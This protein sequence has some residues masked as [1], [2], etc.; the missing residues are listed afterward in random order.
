MSD[1]HFFVPAYFTAEA[2]ASFRTR[3]PNVSV[4]GLSGKIIQIQKWNL[5]MRR[6]DSNQVWTSYAGLEVRLIVQ[7][8]RPRFSDPSPANS[9]PTNLFRDDEFKT[10][11]QAFRFQQAQAAAGKA[12]PPLAPLGGAKGGVGQGI[13]N[14][15]GDCWNF[16]QGTTKTVSLRRATSASPTKSPAG[17]KVVGGAKN[18]AKAAAKSAAKKSVSKA[19]A[20]SKFTP[21]KGTAAKKSV[22]R[23]AGRKTPSLTPGAASGSGTTGAVTMKQYQKVLQAATKRR[24]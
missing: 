14:A 16:K 13:V 22:P 20:I 5:E 21:G 1:G 17:A 10:T 3:C 23:K 8:F 6:V 15:D 12:N 9:H 4:D 2:V 19:A 7:D 18:K 24:A 11:I